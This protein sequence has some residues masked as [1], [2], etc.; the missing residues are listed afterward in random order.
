MFVNDGGSHPSSGSWW[1][2]KVGGV[3][4]WPK[5]RGGVQWRNNLRMRQ[6]LNNEVQKCGRNVCYY[7]SV[8]MYR[9]PR[10]E[11]WTAV[12]RSKMESNIIALSLGHNGDPASIF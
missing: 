3:C 2:P 7:I 6:T 5:V 9:I 10:I 8:Y 4:A 1:W 12:Y 11:T